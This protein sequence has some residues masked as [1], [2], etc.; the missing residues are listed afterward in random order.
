MK[1]RSTRP[2]NTR[3]FKRVAAVGLTLPD[4]EAATRYDGSPVLRIHGVFLAGL[5]TH[6]SA[7]PDTL[8][9]RSEIE[10]RELLLSDA[11]D[12]YYVT[13]YY[14]PYPVVLVRLA[15]IGR[16]ALVDLLS[17]SRRLAAAKTRRRPKSVVQAR[18][19][20]NSELI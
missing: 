6:P 10:D 1:H 8:V 18:K 15:S 9:V 20:T 2:L 3:S 14:R 11:P 17:I 5:A 19:R 7:A 12:T 13:D 16:D 4:V